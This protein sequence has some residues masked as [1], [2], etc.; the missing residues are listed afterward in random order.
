MGAEVCSYS[1]ELASPNQAVFSVP[2]AGVA[3]AQRC[4]PTGVEPGGVGVPAAQANNRGD[5]LG[6][7]DLE[8]ACPF[9]N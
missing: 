1:S 8:F 7:D 9:A 6:P 5:P 3:Q 2:G 4:G